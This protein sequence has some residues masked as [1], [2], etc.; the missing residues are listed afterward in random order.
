MNN[1][2][3]KRLVMESLGGCSWELDL[4]ENR[5]TYSDEFLALIG[6]LPSKGKIELSWVSDNIHPKDLPQWREAYVNH[7]KGNSEY[8][9]CELRFRHRQDY[10]IWMQT[11]GCAIE[12]DPDGRA[13]RVVGMVFDISDRKASKQTESRYRLFLDN[14]P[15][16]ISLKDRQGRYLYINRQFE[17][18][19]GRP[20]YQIHGMTAEQIFKSDF[21][22]L[23]ELMEHEARVWETGESMSMERHFPRTEDGLE[24]M[25]VITKFPVFDESGHM[26]AIGTSNTD[27]TERHRA[28]E[29]IRMSEVRYRRLFESAPAALFESDWTRGRALVDRLRARGIE[30]IGQHLLEH[31]NLVTR[32]DDVLRIVNCNREA[33]RLYRFDDN[34]ALIKSIEGEMI[35]DRRRGLIQALD[36]FA[37][38]MRRS[39][40][41]ALGLRGDG[42]AF[43]M[44][45]ESELISSNRDDWSR[46]LTSVH[47]LS[48]EVE[49]A[50][51][52][53]RYQQELRSLA[54]KISLAEEGERRRISSELH[55]GTVQNLVLAR[56]HLAN[57]KNQLPSG[58]G[59]NL[60]QNI[61]DL[62]QASLRETR[63]LIF[64]ISPPVLYELG[65]EPAVEWLA[66]HYRQRTGVSV[67]VNSGP[68]QAQLS[69]EMKIVVFQAARELLVN[70]TK[71]ARAERI[72]LEWNYHDDRVELAVCDDG[73]GFDASGDTGRRAT[74]GGFGLFSIRERLN[75]LGADIDIQSS[76]EGT[77]AVITAP[78]MPV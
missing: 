50:E 65:L 7:V 36:T 10:Y 40:V 21:S 37:S 52:L 6:Y 62:L 39:S 20:S 54:G 64:E 22:E 17:S 2:D 18:W 49:A 13:S 66:E 44:V 43:H 51:R 76:T 15:D 12:R 16:A 56:I 78:I 55:D 73:V 41:R 77:R 42:E 46:V 67:E 4:R 11:R 32:R 27:V 23:A 45:R 38:G 72:S 8:F 61:D 35:P 58:D 1:D 24:R 47:D 74:E 33:L 57:L 26:L 30:N 5:I 9:D 25:A 75:L 31:P 48:D 14:I 60:M 70:T 29:A 63:S 28:Q 3:L 34:E 19:L 59:E 68:N 69:E 53:Q 71:H